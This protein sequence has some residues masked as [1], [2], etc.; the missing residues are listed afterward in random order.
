[1]V[2]TIHASLSCAQC[3]PKHEEYPHPAGIAKPE[4]ATCHV[5]AGDDYTRGVH[6][7][8]IANGNGGAPECST[9][10]N[11]AH[12][13]LNPRSI[14]FR[15]GVPDTCGM[16]HSDIGDEFKSSVHGQAIARGEMSA[17]VC[18]DCHGEHLILDKKNL[19]SPISGSNIRETCAQCHAN[20]TL[21]RRFGL[22][23][24]RLTTF[25][26]SFHGLAAKG[27][28]QI[29]ANCASCHGIHNILPSTNEK[30]TI[31][32]DNLPQTCGACHPGAGKRFALGPIHVD[33]AQGPPAMAWVRGFYLVII[34]L[35][36]GLMLLHN[37]G[38]WIRKLI[39][40]HRAGP[41]SR[42]MVPSGELR[43]Y[44]YER[45][46]HGL[47]ASSFIVLAW[48]GI[49]LKYP[50]QWWAA[51]FMISEPLRRNVHRIAATV[52]IGVTFMHL[53]ALIFNR[54]LREHWL[55]MIPR[56]RDVPDA[57]N[58]FAYNLGLRRDKPNLPHHG[59]IEKAEYW[60]V[61]WGTLVMVITGLMLWFNNWSLE[62]LPKSWLDIATM[63]HWFEAIL[64]TLAIVVWHFYSV[65]FDPDVYPMDTAWLTG[66][67]PRRREAGEMAEDEVSEQEDLTE[68]PS[69]SD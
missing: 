4:C 2:G 49:A 11:G 41:A 5:R 18:T 69:E 45:I 13:V 56:W 42:A 28:A 23:M 51:P 68:T 34:P 63:V 32:E 46:S 27:G 55:E 37:G 9:C 57:V 50:D 62:W 65:I 14:D 1:M 44:P 21:T 26:S 25:D 6:G 43:M 8:A 10:H 29:V 33:E 24:D 12:E 16:C 31:H 67:S 38:D 40:F 7:Q 58:G 19:A 64:A 47:L 66:R 48:S 54:R 3:H 53:F 35:T 22:P 60:A 61:V 15:K 59:Y 30:S 36:I 52:M 39:R 17:A 20:V